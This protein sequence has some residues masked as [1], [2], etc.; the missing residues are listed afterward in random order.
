MRR[1]HQFI[2]AGVIAWTS[3]S[4][5]LA[6]D[7]VWRSDYAPENSFQGLLDEAWSTGTVGSL[8]AEWDSWTRFGSH[9]LSKT[10]QTTP[11]IGSN[12]NV[13]FYEY[14]RTAYWTGGNLYGLVYTVD[15]SPLSFGL[16]L[17]DNTPVEGATRD[18]VLRISTKGVLPNTL[19]TLNGVTVAAV[20]TYLSSTTVHDDMGGFTAADAE[21]VWIWKDVPVSAVY[22]FRFLASNAHMSLDQLAVYGSLASVAVPVPEPQTWA[23]MAMGLTALG[24]IRRRQMR[25]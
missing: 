9:T 15:G 11:N 7:N 22:D 3:M 17:T 2:A 12:T 18:F 20:N 10:P 24:L 16:Q 21:W 4:A 1:L 19:A 8:Y 6:V 14:S 5:A 25:H 13:A 23:L